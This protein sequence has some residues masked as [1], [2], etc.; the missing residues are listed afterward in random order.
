MNTTEGFPDD[1]E[2]SI[3][4]VRGIDFSLIPEDVTCSGTHHKL[5]KKSEEMRARGDIKQAKVLNLLAS[6]SSMMMK[7][8]SVNSPYESYMVARGGR[9]TNLDDISQNDL[10]ILR[11]ALPLIGC[12]ALKARV[13][14][15]LWLLSKPR[16]IS[17]VGV[18]IDSYISFPISADSWKL[19][20]EQYWERAAR[21]AIQVKGGAGDRLSTIEG[22]LLAALSKDFADSNYMYLWLAEMLEMLE[23]LRLGE[24]E[25]EK[26][27][28]TCL[29][30][31]EAFLSG[32]DYYAGRQYLEFSAKKFHA[33]G[34]D[35]SWISSLILI[36][37]SYEKEGDE[38][39]KSSGLVAAMNYEYAIQSYRK[40][41]A[42][43]RSDYE[44]DKHIGRL[45]VQLKHS[46]KAALG[47]MSR[48][49]TPG[50][51][52][53]D[54]ISA[55]IEHVSKKENLELALLYF[56]GIYKGVIKTSAIESAEDS[57]QKSVVSSLFST[58]Q[59]AS[60]GRVVAKNSAT[61]H[62]PES[63]LSEDALLHQAIQNINIELSMVVEA[64]IFP[65]LNT[66]LEKYR[67]P[68]K[69]L[70]NICTQSPIIPE[71]RE[72]LFA[73]A[74]HAGFEY[75][76]VTSI[77]LLAPQLEHLVR[78]ALKESDVHTTTLTQDGIDME[79]GL[80][81]LLDKPEA[82]E[83]LDENFL[84]ELK[85]LLTDQR[86]PNLRNE[87]AHGLLDDATASSVA[88]VYV[89]WRTLRLVINSFRFYEDE[90]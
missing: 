4:T 26:I 29:S 5:Y 8:E 89:W 56:C 10:K 25:S 37:E 71:N 60:D 36:A 7:P 73:K 65:A 15:I 30:K 63:P 72:H 14:D 74:L 48:V 69:L 9:T 90:Q 64:Q 57:L 3:E 77:H 66:I 67:V 21:L 11:D 19:H 27:A 85:V 84:F 47:E 33:L 38:R 80:S 32:G 16:N 31:G 49:K 82:A 39:A 61:E 53:S 22:K 1:L 55:S 87:V 12:M 28:A 75:D 62:E 70:A 46:G 86:G 43:F 54:V 35:N 42:K 68:Y 13:A 52:V 51:D 78:V 34:D 81:T 17:D 79:C 83:I 2:V 20:V 24:S 59:L 40:V 41:P 18:V 50:V 58:V 6:V 44:V 45:R 76:F 23:M 88:S